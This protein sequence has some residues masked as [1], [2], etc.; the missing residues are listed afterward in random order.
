LATF[1]SGT[2]HVPILKGVDPDSAGIWRIQLAP[3]F[4]DG[5]ATGFFVGGGRGLLIPKQTKNQDAAWSFIEY[6][7]L[8]P[9]GIKA[10]WEGGGITPSYKPAFDA[11]YFDKTDPYYGDQP[12]GRIIVDGLKQLDGQQWFSGPIPSGIMANEIVGPQLRSLMLN[13]IDAQTALDAILAGMEEN[14]P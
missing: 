4:P 6:M 2:F 3:T 14:L 12:V 8:T 11:D 1:V 7:M 9:E 10:T 13:E 5:K